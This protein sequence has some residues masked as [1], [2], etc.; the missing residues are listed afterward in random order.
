LTTTTPAFGHPSSAEEGTIDNRYRLLQQAESLGRRVAGKYPGY[1]GGMHVFR[2]DLCKHITEIGGQREIATFKE[3]VGCQPRPF[4]I[5]LSAFH[6]PSGDEECAGVTVIGSARSVLFN[7]SS[8]LCHC[9]DDDIPHAV[10]QIAVQRSDSI[11]E[12]AETLTQ[13]PGYTA[14]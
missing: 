14:P 7:G 4:A 9:H 8:E 10:T 5:N 1:I 11:A 12:L 13:L 6:R 2:K 3:S